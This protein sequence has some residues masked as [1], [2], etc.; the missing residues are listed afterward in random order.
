MVMGIIWDD[1]GDSGPIVKGSDSLDYEEFRY[2]I[3]LQNGL[4]KEGLMKAGCM[5]DAVKL[6]HREHPE[7]VHVYVEF[8]GGGQAMK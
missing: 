7:A 4:V 1:A 5:G 8:I 6:L 3:T 2:K